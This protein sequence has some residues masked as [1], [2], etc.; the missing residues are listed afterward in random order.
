MKLTFDQSQCFAV[1]EKLFSVLNIELV[2]WANANQSAT[3]IIFNFRDVNYSPENGGFH[4]VEIRLI[5]QKAL[6]HFDYITDF[7]YQG[8][9]YPELVKEIDVCFQSA[10]VTHLH[11]GLLTKANADELVE[12]FLTNFIDYV[13][14]DVF[15]V[16]I[17][18]S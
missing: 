4:P 5:K 15:T 2:K 3:S 11:L 10:E 9:G 8:T 1:P 18:F 13:E 16:E 17:A 14:M 6:W 12:L 7:S